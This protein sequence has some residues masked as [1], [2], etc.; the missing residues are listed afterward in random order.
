[1]KKKPITQNAIN[2]AFAKLEKDCDFNGL[3]TILFDE[4]GFHTV[5][6][7]AVPLSQILLGCCGAIHKITESAAKNAREENELLH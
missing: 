2:E 5:F 1:M 4:E 6:R 7:G 3:V